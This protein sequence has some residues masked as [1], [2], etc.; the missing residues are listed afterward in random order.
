MDERTKATARQVLTDYLE[1]QGHRKT[2]ER[3]AVL[4]VVYSHKGRFLLEN[5]S[6]E[7]VKRNFR[8]SRATLYNTMN[9]FIKLQLVVKYILPDGTW[10]EACYEKRTQ[11]YQVCTQ[12][13]KTKELSLP[14]V[15]SAVEGSHLKRFRKEGFVLYV[16]GICSSC[17]AKLTRMRTARKRNK[18]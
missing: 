5:L 2:P 10:Y 17:Q 7:L 9:L 15:A 1:T 16:Y 3:Y 4:D 11:S 8:V 13:G 18:Q 12:C 6:D 14:L